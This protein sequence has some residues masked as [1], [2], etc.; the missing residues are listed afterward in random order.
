MGAD[1]QTASYVYRPL[2]YGNGHGTPNTG[3]TASV[4]TATSSFELILWDTTVSGTCS[5]S[6]SSER[7]SAPYKSAQ[8]LTQESEAA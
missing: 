6:S 8:R 2:N 5:T 1:A 7:Q 4:H 3:L